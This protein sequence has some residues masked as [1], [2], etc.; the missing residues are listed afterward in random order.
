MLLDTQLERGSSEVDRAVAN[1][2]Q[3]AGD[4][5]AELQWSDLR[6][7]LIYEREAELQIVLTDRLK[8][9]A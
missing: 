4:T 1:V 6:S 2:D 5:R 3:A 9:R 8:F 7:R